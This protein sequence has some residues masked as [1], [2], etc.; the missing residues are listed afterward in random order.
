MSKPDIHWEGESGRRYGYWIREIGTSFKDKPGNY[1][2]A[3]ETEPN[4]WRPIYIGQTG[5]LAD[6]LADHEK[7]E[8]ALENG[9]THIHAHVNTGGEQ[10]RQAEETDLIRRWNTACND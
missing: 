7:E 4:R 6:R 3:K 2:Y 9:A 5:S 10:A 8:C 1:I